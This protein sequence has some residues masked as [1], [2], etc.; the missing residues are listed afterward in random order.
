MIVSHRKFLHIL[1]LGYDGVDNFLELYCGIVME[2]IEAV[3]Q[4]AALSQATTN[5]SD[6][7]KA[8]NE[9]GGDSKAIKSGA[10]NSEIDSG[11]DTSDSCDEKK[12][13]AGKSESAQK[14]K[15]HSRVAQ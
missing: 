10:T 12:P 8:P 14:K 4:S 13:K 3:R 9:A 5:H 15:Q 2:D 7:K 1:F 6:Q 11:I